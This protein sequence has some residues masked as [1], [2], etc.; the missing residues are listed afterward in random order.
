MAKSGVVDED[1]T[2]CSFVLPYAGMAMTATSW[3]VVSSAWVVA[4]ARRICEDHQP[5][6]PPYLCP[7][8]VLLGKDG[9]DEADHRGAVRKD[10]DHVG[11]AADLWLRPILGTPGPDLAPDQAM[12]RMSASPA[13]CE[14]WSPPESMPGLPRDPRSAGHLRRGLLFVTDSGHGLHASALRRP[15]DLAGDLRW[16]ADP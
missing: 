12:S 8:V 11:A 5:D 6:V 14:R 2:T 13:Y 3:A 1:A 9:A 15:G 16:P 4:G 7:L 10:A